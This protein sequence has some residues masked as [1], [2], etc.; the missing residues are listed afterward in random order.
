MWVE[1]DMDQMMEDMIFIVICSAMS[2]PASYLVPLFSSV[3]YKELLGVDIHTRHG[4]P[5]PSVDVL[6]TP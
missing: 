4:Y 1:R 3:S 2:S 5:P 6:S